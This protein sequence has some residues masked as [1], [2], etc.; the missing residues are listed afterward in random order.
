MFKLGDRVEALTDSPWWK[1]G[2]RGVVVFV[3]GWGIVEIMFDNGARYFTAGFPFKK[4]DT[5]LG[6]V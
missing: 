5:N 6:D 4:I 2:A 3:D 1:A